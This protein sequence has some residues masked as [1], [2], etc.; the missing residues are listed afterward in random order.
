MNVLH[1]DCSISPALEKLFSGS[2]LQATRTGFGVSIAQKV[3]Q[4]KET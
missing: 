3:E 1:G 2:G 4:K